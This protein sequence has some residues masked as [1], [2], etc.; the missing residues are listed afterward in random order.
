MKKKL[1]LL[2][3]LM[4][5]LG[6]C[7]SS[8]TPSSSAS[9]SQPAS[10]EAP[11]LD[12]NV[13]RLT[14]NFYDPGWQ[15]DSEF[16]MTRVG[17]E[18]KFVYEEIDLF[19]DEEWA[20]TVN[21]DWA[22]Q[23]GFTGTTNLTVVDSAN[24]M[25][26]GGGPGTVKNFKVLTDGNYDIEL[27]TGVSPRT[28]T[29]TRNGDPIDVPVVE[30]DPEEWHLVGTM[31]GWDPA[32]LSYP[33]PYNPTLTLYTGT[34]ELEADSKFKI[35]SAA[36]GFGWNLSRN[37]DHLDV[38]VPAPDWLNTE[39]DNDRNI[40]ITEAG[41]YKIDFIWIAS[42]GANV[43][44]VIYIIKTA[45]APV[46][47]P[48][49]NAL[50]D[51][52]VSDVVNIVEGYVF[53]NIPGQNVAGIA[54]KTGTF[55]IN[56]FDYRPASTTPDAVLYGF[57]TALEEGDYI[58]FSGIVTITTGGDPARSK[59]LK[60]TSGTL[61][62]ASTWEPGEFLAARTINM[63]T[64]FKD[65]AMNLTVNDIGRIYTF[66]NVK[67]MSVTNA[68]LTGTGYDYL[69]YTNRVEG[70]ND[71]LATNYLR[72]GF[73][74]YVLPN[75]INTTDLYTVTAFFVG[76]NSDLPYSGYSGSSGPIMRLSGYATITPQVV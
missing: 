70:K 67:F 9:S 12:E 59:H 1:I 33:L 58:S 65:W 42:V 46:D 40:H 43:R 74:H 49:L 29:I 63:D 55:S 30:V 60:P 72:V 26:L 45:D 76:T 32:D 44:G 71:L 50:A 51:K 61:L 23:I 20:I 6:A 41:T 37:F 56:Y 14:G 28:V 35:A 52:N 54:V 75:T 4:L 17:T 31:N 21:G 15:P 64:E 19:V 34:Y 27:N 69:N 66:T 53:Y 3:L 39:S 73:Y 10:S 62:P 11:T 18:N 36:D 24:T 5:A 2:P 38:D 22:G 7:G 25:G 57:Y 8:V 16:V 47:I 48:A 68:T 13:Y